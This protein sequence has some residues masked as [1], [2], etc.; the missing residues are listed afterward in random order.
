[1]IAIEN[2]TFGFINEKKHSGAATSQDR[3]YQAVA[4][5]VP[6]LAGP[7]NDLY[8]RTWRTSR[9]IAARRRSARKARRR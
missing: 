9:A 3:G 6:N 7:F 5:R 1:V 4:P 2:S 8:I